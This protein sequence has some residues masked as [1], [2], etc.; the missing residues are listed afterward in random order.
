MHRQLITKC[1]TA[2]LLTTMREMDLKC[3]E[4]SFLLLQFRAKIR[5]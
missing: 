3:V 2:V 5:Q 1:S 4:F